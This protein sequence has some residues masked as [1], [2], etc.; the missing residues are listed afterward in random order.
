MDD[1]AN[2][3]SFLAVGAERAAEMAGKHL[4]EIKDIVGFLRLPHNPFR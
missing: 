4:D 2:I 3:D 1:P